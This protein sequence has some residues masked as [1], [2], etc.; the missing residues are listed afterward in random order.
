[1]GTRGR[2]RKQG[3]REANGKLSRKPEQVAQRLNEAFD[4]EEREALAVGV[5][6]R[7]RLWKVP[8]ALSRDQKLGSF[9]G[10]LCMA[11][12]ISLAQ[13]DAAMKWLE[14]CEAH[15]WAIASPKRPN[16][17][18]INAARGAPTAPE[19][20]SLVARIMEKHQ[21]AKKAVQAEQDIL[22][23]HAH[24]FGALQ[25]LVEQDVE[26]HHLVGDLRYALNALARFYKL[27]EREAA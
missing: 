25:Y 9:V 24:L 7:M 10:R 14:S 4:R 15:S 11:R 22:G 18:D 27:E 8:E 19:N 21:G 2:K 6:A 13:Y 1:M 23:L 26:L 3:K 5:E 20:L 12:E 17:V 16:A